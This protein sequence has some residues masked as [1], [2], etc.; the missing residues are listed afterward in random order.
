[1]F[2]IIPLS[3]LPHFKFWSQ[4]LFDTSLNTLIKSFLKFCPKC[5]ENDGIVPEYAKK[6]LSISRK[7]FLLFLRMSTYKESNEGY[8]SAE[9]FGSLHS[10]YGWLG[11]FEM[12]LLCSIYANQTPLLE[13]LCENVIKQNRSDFKASF[14]RYSANVNQTLGAIKMRCGLHVIDAKDLGEDLNPCNSLDIQGL[15][16]L[17]EISVDLTYKRRSCRKTC[18]TDS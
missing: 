12:S 2:L 3:R 4:I 8:M 18:P 17:I 6:H 7:M 5:W 1:M 13:K 14:T 15:T 10:K 9:F 11:A 16:R